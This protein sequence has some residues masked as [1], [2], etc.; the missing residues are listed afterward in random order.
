M[1]GRGVHFALSP[2]Q[3]ARLLPAVGDDASVLDL[4]EEIEETWDEQHLVESDKAWDPIHRCFCD[5][6]LLY[7]GG[8][9]PLNH[10]ICGGRQCLVDEDAEQ[11]LSYVSAA[12]VKQV[13]EAARHISRDELRQRYAR[14]KQRGYQ[15]RL[16]DEDFGYAWEN[17]VVLA[18][19]FQRAASAERAVIFS[20]DC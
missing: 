13:A 14:I 19:F 20:T 5:G 11:T 12:Q 8:D 16:G 3:E 4:L 10:L 15:F 6:K 18:A 9:H 7:E 1:A 2:E 17:F